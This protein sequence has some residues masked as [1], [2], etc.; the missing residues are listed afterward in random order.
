MRWFESVFCLPDWYRFCGFR[1]DFG[2]L[3]GVSC[4]VCLI[5]VGGLA[6][7]GWEYTVIVMT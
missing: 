4:N 7:V 1:F 3:S 5:E 6:M 2:L